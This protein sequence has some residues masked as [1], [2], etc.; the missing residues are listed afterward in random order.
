[1]Q[2]LEA[3]FFYDKSGEKPRPSTYVN[4][5]PLAEKKL[6]ELETL[7]FNKTKNPKFDSQFP[8]YR[9]LDLMHRLLGFHYQPR[10]AHPSKDDYFPYLKNIDINKET[11]DASILMYPYVPALLNDIIMMGTQAKGEK[12]TGN[13]HELIKNDTLIGELSILGSRC[14]KSYAAFLEFEEKEK[15]YI[16]TDSQKARMEKRKQELSQ[17]NREGETVANFRF[18]DIKGKQVSLASLKGK[19]VVID[20][21]A[22]WCG[23]CKQQIPHLQKMEKAYHGK[24]VAFV[25]IST[26][27][28]LNE[29]GDYVKSKGLTGIQLY[30]DPGNSISEIY[31]INAIPHFLVIDKDDKLVSSDAPRPSDPKLKTLIDSLMK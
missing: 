2:S 22:T 6:K 14:F 15:K 31:N 10:V 3:E 16:L 1:M 21:W 11:S 7:K 19:V 5:Y 8:R 27:K 28:N 20:M 17:C 4:F 24:D 18:P 13:Y 12:Y 26:D 25:S 29:W 9:E 23:S 30:G